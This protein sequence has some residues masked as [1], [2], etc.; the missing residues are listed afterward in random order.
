MGLIFEWKIH[1][2]GTLI[3]I[4]KSSLSE[5]NSLMSRFWWDIK[6]ISIG[7]LGWLGRGWEEVRRLEDWVLGS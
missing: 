5:I 1:R 2:S 7:L 6:T 4:Q 3:R